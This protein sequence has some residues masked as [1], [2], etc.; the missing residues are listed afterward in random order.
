MLVSIL[1]PCFNRERWIAQAIASALGQTWP[2]KEVIVLDDGSAD[3]SLDVIK[4]FG[5]RIRWETGSN[6]GG[7]VARNRLL[8]LA[9]GNWLQ[10]LD[11]DDYLLPKK[12]ADQMAF[13]EAHPETQIVFGPVIQEYWS[14]Q[15]VRREL[16]SIPEPHDLWV[17]LARWYLP[18]TGSPLWHKQAILDVGGWK[19]DQPCCQE[20]ELYLR[21]LMGGKRFAY[22]AEGGA[23]YRRWGKDTVCTS[24][25]SEVR[26]RRLEIEQRVEEFLRQRAELTPARHWAINQARF[27]TA[28]TAW[29]HD[30]LE[31]QGIIRTIQQSYPAFVPEGRAASRH[32]RA[33]YRLVGFEPTEVLAGW[34]RWALGTGLDL[35]K[36]SCPAGLRL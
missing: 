5:E 12:V 31:A 11:A 6:R 24:D 22:F 14:E 3:G 21:L 19:P 30:R 25:M 17:L 35:I 23:V 8:E 20:H 36:W 10:F 9:N 15:F 1:I 13:I 29:Q 7:N 16:L 26:R 4:G 33:V 34:R 32:Y 27:E 28:R 2:E 18:Q